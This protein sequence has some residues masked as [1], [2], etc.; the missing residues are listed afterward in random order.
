MEICI[1]I[2]R[3]EGGSRMS[4]LTGFV[5]AAFI[6]YKNIMAFCSASILARHLYGIT[7][8]CFDMFWV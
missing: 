7:L 1:K 5:R 8:P 2:Q 4:E 3:L 6:A